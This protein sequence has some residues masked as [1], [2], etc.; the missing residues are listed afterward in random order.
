LSAAYS[1]NQKLVLLVLKSTTDASLRKRL[2]QQSEPHLFRVQDIL[3]PSPAESTLMAASRIEILTTL[4]QESVGT[5]TS[6]SDHSSGGGGQLLQQTLAWGGDDTSTLPLDSPAY[7]DC[8]EFVGHRPLSYPG[9][10][11]LLTKLGIKHAGKPTECHI[12]EA[13]LRSMRGQYYLQSEL[14]DKLIVLYKRNGDRRREARRAIEKGR[15]VMRFWNRKD[16]EGYVQ[17]EGIVEHYTD[18]VQEVFKPYSREHLALLEFRAEMATSKQE[19]ARAFDLNEHAFKIARILHGE[20]HRAT[21]R[22]FFL[23]SILRPKVLAKTLNE[24]ASTVFVSTGGVPYQLPTDYPRLKITH[25]AVFWVLIPI[26]TEDQTK[27]NE[28]I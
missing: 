15:C 22:H 2:V 18:M 10:N 19:Y 16:R 8:V 25:P 9:Q 13:Q 20:T 5:P 11:E 3:D 28:L 6:S 14:C 7:L 24:T 1:L 4:K 27:L 23:M 17:L 26:Y 12:L 21:M